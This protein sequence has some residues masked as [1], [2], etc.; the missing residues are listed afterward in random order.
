MDT[1]K[2]LESIQE[3]IKDKKELRETY[4]TLWQNA[5]FFETITLSNKQVI[6]KHPSLVDSMI[7][8]LDNLYTSYPDKWRSMIP[9]LTNPA[10]TKKRMA[11][12]HIKQ[13]Q[14]KKE[15]GLLK[16]SQE[17]IYEKELKEYNNI[18]EK[19]WQWDITTMPGIDLTFMP[20][21]RLEAKNNNPDILPHKIIS[22]T[23]NFIPKKNQPL[24][25]NL[26]NNNI[27]QF[28]ETNKN[29]IKK[30]T[31]IIEKLDIQ[32]PE[33]QRNIFENLIHCQLDEERIEKIIQLGQSCEASGDY[34]D[35]IISITDMFIENIQKTKTPQNSLIVDSVAKAKESI[36]KDLTQWHDWWREYTIKQLTSPNLDI[37]LPWYIYIADMIRKYPQTKIIYLLK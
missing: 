30:I 1:I 6:Y 27:R 7:V 16:D 28:I 31:H 14:A 36:K 11:Q 35:F 32:D 18:L 25:E 17:E 22:H 8:V 4:L 21:R 5:W 24:M 23:I 15:A 26:A 20:L 3:N 33:Q 29:Q 34:Y 37:A 12:Q 13:I 10:E 19:A 2:W 9:Q